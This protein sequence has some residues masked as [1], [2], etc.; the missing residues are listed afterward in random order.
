[1]MLCEQLHCSHQPEFEVSWQVKLG[2]NLRTHQAHL[3]PAM[4]NVYC[5]EHVAAMQANRRFLVHAVRPLNREQRR[6]LKRT[7]LPGAKLAAL[8]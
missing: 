6:K 1:M 4:R 3:S 8:N 2:G 7:R 5:A